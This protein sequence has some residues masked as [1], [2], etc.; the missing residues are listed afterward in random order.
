MGRGGR[1][2]QNH[3][4]RVR[5]IGIL[6]YKSGEMEPER[7]LG[8]YLSSRWSWT[9]F[10]RCCHQRGGCHGEGEAGMASGALGGGEV[11]AE[12]SRVEERDAIAECVS[13]REDE[14]K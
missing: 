3:K 12:K 6:G 4:C 11:I 13:V 10:S 7:K 2:S 9:L 1:K 14:E 8:T 5:K